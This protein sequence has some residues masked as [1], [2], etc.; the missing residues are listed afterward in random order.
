ML[1]QFIR[2]F[3]LEQ[4]KVFDES[5]HRNRIQ[6]LQTIEDHCEY[7]LMYHRLPQMYVNSASGPRHRIPIQSH[8]GDSLNYLERVYYMLNLTVYRLVF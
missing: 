5:L 3:L 4:L 1:I 7:P 8:I 6:P 2:K